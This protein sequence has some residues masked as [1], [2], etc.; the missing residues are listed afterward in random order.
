[1]NKTGAHAHDRGKERLNLNPESINA[2]Q[3]AVDKMW[4]GGGHRKL[5][6]NHYHVNIRD[7]H[8]NLIGYAALKRI[9]DQGKRPR[10]ILASILNKHMKPRGTNISE[11]IHTKI[12]DNG[13]KLHTP[14]KYK[15][16]DPIPDNK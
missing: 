11:F 7:P 3:R 16:M 4:F 14:D 5:P 10:L 6:D 1:M 2:L 8:K 13:V 9:N 12:H 15:G